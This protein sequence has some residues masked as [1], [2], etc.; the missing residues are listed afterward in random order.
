VEAR[1]MKKAGTLKCDDG[2]CGDAHLTP[3]FLAESAMYRAD[4]LQDWIYDLLKQYNKARKELGWRP[5]GLVC[6]DDDPVEI[7]DSDLP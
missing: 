1:K 3:S 6:T 7:V 2:G 5:A 4:V